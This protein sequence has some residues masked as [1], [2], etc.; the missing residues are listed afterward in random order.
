MDDG[1]WWPSLLHYPVSPPVT[2]TVATP[3]LLLLN[4][5]FGLMGVA[6]IATYVMAVRR[7]YLEKVVAVP[8]LAVC[9][10]VSW[11]FIYAFVFHIRPITDVINVMFTVIDAI[12]LVQV[13]KYGH[14]DAKSLSRNGFYWSAGGMVVFALAA[15]AAS[16]WD[17]ADRGG[18]NGW[19]T[20][21]FTSVMFVAML[22]QRKSTAGQ[23][24]YIALVKM[25]GTLAA[26]VGFASLY[27]TRTLMWVF[28]LTMTIFDVLYVFLL[29][30]QFK[31]EGVSPWRKL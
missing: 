12:L 3:P 17:F 30:R 27:P 6:W 13:F 5:A 7:G 31:A 25:I 11:E 22:N 20:T 14:R 2:D 1:D 18:Y 26:T 28:Y 16:A 24:M 10:N 9:T 21:L 15:H 23:T 4:V 29:Y 19:A 8:W